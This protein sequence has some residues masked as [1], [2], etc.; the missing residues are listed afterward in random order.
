MKKA[1]LCFVIYKEQ[2]LMI[3][4]NKPPFMGLWN[5]LGGKVKKGESIFEAGAREVF[6][7][8]GISLK[9]DSFSLLSSFTWNYDDELGYALVASLKEK[10]FEKVSYPQS[11]S[12][13]IVDFKKIDWV[14]DAKNYGVIPDLRVFISDIKNGEKHDYHLVYDNEKLIEVIK[15]N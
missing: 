1:V 6:E 14:I 3:N 8:S 11:L 5:A 2:V 10:D 7:E 12:E 4:R 9:P 13:G 15:K